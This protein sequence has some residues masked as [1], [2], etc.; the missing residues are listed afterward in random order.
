ME[1]IKFFDR[2]V[3]FSDE[4]LTKLYDTMSNV[5]EIDNWHK[6]MDNPISISPFEC[7]YDF[8]NDVRNNVNYKNSKFT[9]N[10]RCTFCLYANT[11]STTNLFTTKF[12]CAV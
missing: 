10:F 4:L 2:T 1:L 5:H 11:T 12:T 8:T 6:Y 7:V 3:V 9:A